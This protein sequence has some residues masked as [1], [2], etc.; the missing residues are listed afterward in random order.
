MVFK[1]LFVSDDVCSFFKNKSKKS[2]KI[3]FL[4]PVCSIS[5]QKSLVRLGKGLRAGVGHLICNIVLVVEIRDH[6]THLVLLG[7]EGLLRTS[8]LS[9]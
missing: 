2:L 5:H 4:P 1:L 7:R 8:H 6:L 9:A 3:I